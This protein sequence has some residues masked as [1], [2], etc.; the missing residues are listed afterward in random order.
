MADTT[1]KLSGTYDS[2]EAYR[3]L[4]EMREMCADFEDIKTEAETAASTATA[5]VTTAQAAANNASTY[6][7]NAQ[8]Y[9]GNANTSA[10]EAAGYAS[11]ASTSATNAATSETNA[12]NSASAAATSES[13]AA[14]SETN[15]SDS[16]TAAAA[17]AAEVEAA[18]DDYIPLSGGTLT[19]AIN[20]AN[21]TWNKLGDDASFGDH[22]VG[23]KM[24]IKTQT[25]TNTG[26]AFF[27]S[28]D[29][30]VGQV[31]V[32]NEFNF[33]KTIKQ[34]GTAVSLS[35]H[36]HSY[37]PLSGG[38]LTGEVNGVTPT[39]GDN[40]TKLATTAFV[41]TAVDVVAVPTGVVQ[42]F[43]GTTI[44]TGW[45]LCD[46]SAVSRTT[47]ANLYACIGDTYGAGD[48]STTFNLPNLI[49][50]FIEGSST[51]GTEKSAGLPNITGRAITDPANGSACPVRNYEGAFTSVEKV[52]IDKFTTNGKVN[53][54]YGI[55]FDASRSSPI[56]GNSTTV[57]PPALTMR[58]IIKY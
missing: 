38:T 42:A 23:G 40:S 30:N 53:T 58:Y 46:G 3:I 21:N 29:T 34:S 56:Y 36:T 14:T 47:Y 48:G 43:A 2:I 55:S 28:S 20:T 22:N 25:S 13:N 18:L 57:Q 16:A 32:N 24:C 41:K 11:N 39:A 35:G 54:T 19:G 6:A 27:N 44:P 7:T 4:E 8:T 31:E 37:L 1:I 52:S 49:D 50:K 33:N 45:L 51:A 9:A 5:A 17:S 10:G 15:A 26:I 12:S